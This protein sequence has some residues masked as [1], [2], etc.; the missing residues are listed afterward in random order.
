MNRLLILVVAAAL[1]LGGCVG[2]STYEKK[3]AEADQLATALAA[4][5]QDYS[6]LKIEYENLETEFEKLGIRSEALEE[7]LLR[8][9]KDIERLEEVLSERSIETGAA[10][11][12]MR[13]E[14]DRL[15]AEKRDLELAVESERI[16]RQARIAQ[17]KSTY[18][19]LVDKMEAEIERGE[20]TISELQG[21]LTVN[22]VDKILFPS[23]S[24]TI[25][26]EG[27]KVLQKVGDIVKNVKGKDI[28]VEELSTA[29]ATSVV[30]FLR[31]LGIPGERL[32]AVGY[33]QYRPVAE[34]DTSE[35]RAH[36]RRIQ[37][38]LVPAKE[39]FRKAP[40]QQ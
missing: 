28:Q 7:D 34:N 38:V 25:K 21:D 1:T 4:L 22:M 24:A 30:R 2:K 3:V 15:E 26:Q 11:A 31:T 10:M 29:R 16:A 6:E 12:E 5:E 23:G 37:I 9:R 8:A 19:E 18:D 17:I 36:N 39:R 40:V 35:G 33:G 20:I 27:L 32:A 14:I 13:Q